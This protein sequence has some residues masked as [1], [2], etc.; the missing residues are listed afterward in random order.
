MVRT[1]LT[2]DGEVLEQGEWHVKPI[3]RCFYCNAPLTA[4]SNFCSASQNH[5]HDWVT[6]VA[7]ANRR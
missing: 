5:E 7:P 6:I 1:W 2:L 4:V 3:H